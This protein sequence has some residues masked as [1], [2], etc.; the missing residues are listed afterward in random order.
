MAALVCYLF[1]RFIQLV[2]LRRSTVE[3]G[4]RHLV[5]CTSLAPD[6]SFFSAGS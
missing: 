2:R 3:N 5:G 6:S 4:I 1:G